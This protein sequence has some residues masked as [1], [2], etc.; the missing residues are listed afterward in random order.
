MQ[1]TPN[2]VSQALE[3][4]RREMRH[5]SEDWEGMCQAFC[6][7]IYGVG[8]LYGSAYAQWLAADDSHKHRGGD[9]NHAPVG[10]LLCFK[11][12]SR[13]GHIMIAAHP[14]ADGRKAAYSNDLVKP[15][16]INKVGRHRPITQWSQDYLGYITTINNYEIHIPSKPVVHLDSIVR[17]AHNDPPGEQG[18]KT[19]PH[20]VRIVERALHREGLLPER[21]SEDGSFGS[22]T[23]HAYSRWQRHLGYD[24]RDANGI[25]GLSSL[26]RLGRRHGF[27][28]KAT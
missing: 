25:P 11:G 19:A 7:D 9:P 8:A 16:Q 10:S 13:F 24:G 20:Q 17:A 15:G 27:V 26:R 14:F 3:A 21:Y 1:R 23:L 4:A 6:H 22:S 12:S 5:E 18:H 2:T 28:V